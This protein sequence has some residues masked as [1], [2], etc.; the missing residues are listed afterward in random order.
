M[1]PPPVFSL[2]GTKK[3]TDFVSRDRRDNS[4]HGRETLWF[5][6]YTETAENQAEGH[7]RSFLD[8]QFVANFIETAENQA[9]GHPRSFLDDQSG[10]NF[11]S[12]HNNMNSDVLCYN[13]TVA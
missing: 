5:C 7:P 8:D 2:P 6:Q 12:H 10:A 4:R 11:I 9:E 3:K 13:R 1:G